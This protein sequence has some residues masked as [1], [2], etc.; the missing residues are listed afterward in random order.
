M[1]KVVLKANFNF[2]FTNVNFLT[3]TFILTLH[4]TGSQGYFNDPTDR[5]VCNVRLIRC[6]ASG[7]VIFRLSRCQKD[8]R[9]KNVS[10]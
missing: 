7:W 4:F 5:Y 3:K 8:D 9:A 1:S 10:L 6:A 2:Q